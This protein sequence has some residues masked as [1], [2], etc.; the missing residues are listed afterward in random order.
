VFIHQLDTS[1]EELRRQPSG[2]DRW[3]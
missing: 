3:S 1:V 2:D